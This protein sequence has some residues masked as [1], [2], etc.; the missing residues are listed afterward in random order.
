M[1][2]LLRVRPDTGEDC[3]I[4]YDDRADPKVFCWAMSAY[5]DPKSE[6]ARLLSFF[7][8]DLE[9]FKHR[10]GEEYSLEQWL[11]PF[12]KPMGDWDD[13][14]QEQ[15]LQAWHVHKA[16]I[17]EAYRGPAVFLSAL[18]PF[19]VALATH[20]TVYEEIGITDPYFTEENFLHH[21]QDLKRKFE[22]AQN[23]GIKRVRLVIA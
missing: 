9:P 14:S 17:E 11:S 1:G 16:K 18:D 15:K 21:L 5:P 20:P 3:P 19:I 13:L 23:H 12:F 10:T 6:V 7:H 2:V 22:W 8:L 4:S